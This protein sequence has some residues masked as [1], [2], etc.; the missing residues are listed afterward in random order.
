MDWAKNKMFEWNEITQTAQIFTSPETIDLP[1]IHLKS[2]EGIF[3]KYSNDELMKI[4][5][6]ESLLELVRSIRD[7]NDLGANEHFLPRDTFEHLFNLSDGYNINTLIN[8]VESGKIDASTMYEQ[9]GSH[10]NKRSFIE[11]DDKLIEEFINGD[12]S[13]WQ[14]FLHPTQ[15]RLVEGDFRGSVKVTGG[16]GTGKTVVA[17]HRLKYLSQKINPTSDSKIV[18]TTFTN[19]LT[20]N[21]NQLVKK[22]HVDSNTYKI[23]NIDSLLRELALSNQ[24]IDS[25]TRFI[26]MFNSKTSNEIWEIILENNLSAFEVSFLSA[27]YQNVV[28]NSN[29]NSLETYLATSRIGRGKPITRKQKMEIWSLIEKY[30]EYKVIHN[31]VDRY[32]LFNKVS[33]YFNSRQEK[34][35]SYVIADEI[36]DLSNLELRF[37]RSLVEEKE[38]D[39]FLV[40][41]PY[42]KI[43]AKKLNF[44]RAGISIKGNRSKQ[45]RINYRTSEEI[46]RLAIS[47]VKGLNYDDFDGEEETLNGYLSMFHGQIPTYNIFRTKTEEFDF[48]VQ[49]IKELKS[50]GIMYSE[51]AIGFRT[52]DALREVKSVLHKLK[53]P[54]NDN[55]THATNDT[56]GIVLS[57]FHGLKGLEFK[58]VLLADVNNRTCPLYYSG[59][60]DLDEEAKL[61]YENSEKS[62][63]YVAM[64]R[65]VRHLF[66]SGIGVKSAVIDI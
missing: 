61:Q 43:Y 3:N 39:L 24:L 26:D 19:A 8:E 23:I 62:L 29:V 17:L 59:Y 25:N 54:Y 35:F 49:R 15:R 52:K 63:V 11:V 21:L 38:N 57:T 37:L 50:E 13:K 60:N 7:L 40:G 18:F 44:S 64:T 42:Q 58:A 2:N 53:L 65:A 20:S 22:L 12:L 9:Q 6:P 31:L 36:Q 45:L 41:D 51:V 14:I 56:G 33:N 34:P 16:A 28:L 30:N 55:T 10:N 1:V 46:K 5:V 48:L 32:E 47:T 27:E 4:G 66:I